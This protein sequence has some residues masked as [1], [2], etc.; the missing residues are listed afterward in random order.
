VSYSQ[1]F[2]S[3][4]E[5]RFTATLPLKVRARCQLCR[6]PQRS[7]FKGHLLSALWRPTNSMTSRS[8]RDAI[9]PPYAFVLLRFGNT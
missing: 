3:V 1:H 2:I 4:T 7:P 9:M 8:A 6:E 5:D